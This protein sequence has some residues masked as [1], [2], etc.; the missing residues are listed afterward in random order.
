MEV[1]RSGQ[2]RYTD[3]HSEVDQFAQSFHD[4]VWLKH[5]KLQEEEKHSA[6][7]LHVKMKI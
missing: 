5:V 3:T 1:V 7:L 2:I 6:S 4:I